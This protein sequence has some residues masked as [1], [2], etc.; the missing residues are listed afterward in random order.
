MLSEPSG[1]CDIAD[2]CRTCRGEEVDVEVGFLPPTATLERLRSFHC[3]TAPY[4]DGW[5]RSTPRF[6][7]PC[8][9]RSAGEVLY[10]DDAR[11]EQCAGRLGAISVNAEDWRNTSAS[12]GTSSPCELARLSSWALPC[13]HL[14]IACLG[15][16]HAP[17]LHLTSYDEHCTRL[18]R[19]RAS[20][21][22]RAI[23][24]SV[25]T[26][27]R[28]ARS[29]S[30]IA[31]LQALSASSDKEWKKIIAISRRAPVLDHKDS[32]VVFESVDL[33]A[34][35]NE[36]V[37]KLKHAGAA[38]AT[39][40]FFYAYIAKEDEQELIDIN[41]KLFGNVRPFSLRWISPADFRFSRLWP[42]SRRSQSN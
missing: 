15:P 7:P 20:R 32:R 21:D 13:L 39:H 11:A 19:Q 25:L 41:R 31:L 22:R 24:A 27:A 1:P 30:G 26:R 8:R 6:M 33:L 34:P 35:K 37:Q 3:S 36:L 5:T 42:L 40:T 2:C 10:G 4:T 16:S 12:S 23:P 38:E 9:G 14:R 29:V 18:R 28:L 17:A